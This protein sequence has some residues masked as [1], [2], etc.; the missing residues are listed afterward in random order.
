MSFREE[1]VCVH[2]C[3]KKR[4]KVSCGFIGFDSCRKNNEIGVDMNLFS[5]DKIRTLN[6]KLVTIGTDLSYH[7]LYVVNSVFFNRAAIE[8]VEVLSWCTDVYIE[9]VYIGVRI[10]IAYEHGVLCRVHT[11]YL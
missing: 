8:F 7:T 4:C 2:A 9:N 1:V 3:R 6:L 10:F 5:V 11:A